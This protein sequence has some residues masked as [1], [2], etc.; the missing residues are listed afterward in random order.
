MVCSKNC[1]RVTP[2]SLTAMSICSR[3]LR[4]IEEYGSVVSFWPRHAYSSNYIF[5]QAAI[6]LIELR[7]FSYCLKFICKK[8]SGPIPTLHSPCPSFPGVGTD[9][10][11]LVLIFIKAILPTL[12]P[13]E[14][15]CD[16]STRT[17]AK[18]KR[19]G[20]PSNVAS[21]M[22]A[23]VAVSAGTRESA[24]KRR[25]PKRSRRPDS[26]NCIHTRSRKIA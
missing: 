7:F 8:R 17:L 11:W 1:E 23:A 22:L 6:L 9:T 26:G 15:A 24:W 2:C 12:L 10:T 5:I 25:S 4:K 21:R 19:E 20:T 14:G 13:N 18:E 16:G 3:L